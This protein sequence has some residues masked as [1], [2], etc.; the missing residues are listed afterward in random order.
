[1]ERLYKNISVIAKI[2][3]VLAFIFAISIFIMMPRGDWVPSYAGVYWLILLSTMIVAALSF[4][5]SIGATKLGAADEAASLRTRVIE[6]EKNLENKQKEID[7][8]RKK[9][10]ELRKEQT[11]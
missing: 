4:L 11:P 6:I 10:G 8:L 2:I 7:T 3:G 5:I 1:M 9:I